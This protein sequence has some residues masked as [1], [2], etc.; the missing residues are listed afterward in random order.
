MKM[1]RQTQQHRQRAT[2]ER[3]QPPPPPGLREFQALGG[4]TTFDASTTCGARMKMVL[5]C[6]QQ[7]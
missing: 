7:E 4:V 1:A 2:L 5:G 6:S 3:K